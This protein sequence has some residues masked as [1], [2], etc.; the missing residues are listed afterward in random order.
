MSDASLAGVRADAIEALYATA[1]W[2]LVHGQTR[3]AAATASA[4]VRLAPHDERGWLTLGAAHEA[5]SQATVALEMYGVGR[6]MAAPAP[7]CE[8]ARAR[9]LASLGKHAESRLAYAAAAEM[10]NGLGQ[11]ALLE[12]IESERT[13]R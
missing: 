2:L 10:A 13:D 3:E 6:V 8:L 1:R 5:S 12:L 9:A 4:L 11:R 7:R